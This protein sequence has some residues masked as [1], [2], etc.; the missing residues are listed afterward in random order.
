[1]S[2]TIIIMVIITSI[3]IVVIVIVVILIPSYELK[4]YSL[5]MWLSDIPI[6]QFYLCI[7]LAVR[8][9]KRATL[10]LGSCYPTS[11][12]IFI[13]IFL[14]FM[15]CVCKHYFIKFV[16]CCYTSL[17]KVI[18]LDVSSAFTHFQFPSIVSGVLHIKFHKMIS[19]QLLYV[20]MY[21]TTSQFTWGTHS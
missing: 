20:Y 8:Y 13:K 14:E 18:L 9:K 4:V 12:S 3:M 2:L 15:Y 10:V 11:Q 6:I 17:K 7:Y 16:P 5:K 21:A 19:L 1:M